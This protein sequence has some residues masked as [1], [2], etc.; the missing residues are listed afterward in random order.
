MSG[1][2]VLDCASFTCTLASASL[3]CAPTWTPVVRASSAPDAIWTL[4]GTRLSGTPKPGSGVTPTTVTVA[5]NWGGD[6]GGG[7]GCEPSPGAGFCASAGGTASHAAI[8]HTALSSSAVHVGS[9][10]PQAGL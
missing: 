3:S 1:W 10:V 7:A 6:G 8:T 2:K 5:L 9:N 4:P